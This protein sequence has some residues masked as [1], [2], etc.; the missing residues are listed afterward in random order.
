M[1][2]AAHFF[3]IFNF[4]VN[5]MKKTTQISGNKVINNRKIRVFL[6]FLLLTSFFWL[7]IQLSKIYTTTVLFNVEYTNL[8]KSKLF[9]SK[10][11]N[12]IE[13]L[14][15]GQGFYLLKLQLITKKIELNLANIT[16]SKKGYYINLNTQ[17]S[18]INSQLQA[19]GEIVSVTPDTL[20][21]DLGNVAT[22]KIPVKPN[23]A[24]NFKVGYNFVNNISI[25]PDSVIV[26]GPQ[27]IIDTLYEINTEKIQLNDVFENLNL[28]LNLN[29]LDENK[30][31][32]ISSG[33]VKL[34]AFVD[35]FTEGKF[36]IPVKVINVPDTLIINTFP[37][38]VEL[39]YQ[40]GIKNF[41]NITVGNFDVSYDFNQYKNDTLIRFLKPHIEVKGDKISSV[42][43]RPEE[44][45]FLIHKK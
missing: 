39:I 5:V 13:T 18:N 41:N 7:L 34:T 12:K 14:V 37:K 22:K 21:F 25:E 2:L 28:N 23:L 43:I 8:P 27:G 38:E 40:T 31:I 6:F 36:Q 29:H 3:C 33:T 20:Y 15:K 17:I 35:K 19:S 11:V 30:V 45:E 1:S 10:P 24:V 32:S 16:T 9:Q 44:I 42:K 26:S 4:G